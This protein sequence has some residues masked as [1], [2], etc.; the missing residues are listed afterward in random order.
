MATQA[1]ASWAISLN[2]SAIPPSV[3]S[4]AIRS[5]YNYIGCTIG[6]SKH[7]T[8]TKAHE[9]LSPFFGRET[10]SLLGHQGKSRTDAQH[11]ALL[12]GIASHVHDYDDT[13]LATIIHPT[14]PIASAVLAY[15]EY[16]G[17]VSG[18][19]ILCALVAGIETSCKIGLAVWP[20]HYDIGWHI[21]STTGSVGAAVAVGKLMNLS[22]DQMQQAIGTAAV[23][24]VGLREMFGSDTKS[25]HPGRAA[26]SGF[27]AALLA[28]K[29]YTSSDKALEAKRGW[30]NVVAGGGTPKLDHYV[31]ELGH[32][33]EI[34]ANAFKPFPCGIVCHPA[35]DGCI[36]LHKDMTDG[37]RKAQDIRKVEARVHPLVIEL[38]SK[39]TPKDGLEG[40]F[41]VFH[42]GAVGLLCGKA[43]P[44]EYDDKVVTDSRVIEL[45]D[46]IDATSD[47][48]L[49]A[50][51]TYLTVHLADG[52]K[53]EKHV[54]H[55]VGSLEVPMTDN[56]LTEKF[57]DQAALVLGPNGARA[58]SDAAWRIGEADDVASVLRAL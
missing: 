22:Q 42:G 33:W 44:A 13:H 34:E 40:K 50:D 55:A 19:S 28:E 54:K 32:K 3:K 8:V 2:A 38:T 43:G 20:E 5:L 11:A 27:L 58:A 51:E 45:R 4:A 17:G 12:N 25:F 9:A 47:E 26:Q 36:Q 41:S 18:E 14:G 57:V 10:S 39:R 29:G 53:I 15:A 49:G 7:P 1:L 48:S 37:G 23:Q 30:A 46:K 21:T 31:S 52:S 16:Q 35:I 24:V 6:G 56:Q